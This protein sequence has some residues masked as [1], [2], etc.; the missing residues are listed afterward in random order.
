[1]DNRLDRRVTWRGTVGRGTALQDGRS[2][3]RFPMVSLLFFID[4]F[5]LEGPG[6]A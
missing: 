1:M 2:R 6:V 5:L 3:V 4:I